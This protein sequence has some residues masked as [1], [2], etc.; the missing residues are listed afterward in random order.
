ME[1]V[2]SSETWIIFHQNEWRCI[3]EDRTPHELECLSGNNSI[4][5]IEKLIMYLKESCLR[6]IKSKNKILSSFPRGERKYNWRKFVF[7]LRKLNC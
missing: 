6:G 4:K 2:Y 1:A 7:F 5:Q 3:P